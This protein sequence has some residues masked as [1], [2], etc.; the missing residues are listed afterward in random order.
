MGKQKTRTRPTIEKIQKAF[1]KRDEHQLCRTPGC[2]NIVDVWSKYS[3]CAVCR[4][5]GK[6]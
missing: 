4:A 6:P 3:T 1:V 2:R 5:E